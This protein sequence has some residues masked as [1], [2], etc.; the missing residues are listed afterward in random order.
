MLASEVIAQQPE[1]S[2]RQIARLAGIS[3]GTARDVRARVRRGLDPVPVRQRTA[4][5]QP[6]RVLKAVEAKVQSA[7]ERESL[8]RKLRS[9][10]SLRCTESGRAVLQALSMH[11]KSMADLEDNV[12]ALPPHCAYVL[13]ELA[14]GV[15]GEWL[16][17]AEKLRRM[18]EATA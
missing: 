13:I 18:T 8:L 12:E 3:M 15:A 16:G 4:V 11:L 6:P 9:D 10:P 14:S 5:Q 2:L 7:S 1:A 17:V